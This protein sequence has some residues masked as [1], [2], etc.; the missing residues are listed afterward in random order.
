MI[1]FQPIGIVKSPVTKLSGGNWGEVQSEIHLNASYVGG[2]KG[3]E[4]FSHIVVVFYLDRST[5]VPSEHLLRRPRGR[6]NQPEV[7][8]FA[9]RSKYRPNLI[10]I[11]TVKL[12]SINHNVLTVLALDATDGTPVLDLKPYMP[13]FDKV[14]DATVPAWVAEFEKGYF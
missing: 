3:L 2:L 13:V 12:L 7:G 10:G 1:Q 14:E 11:T 4:E 6:E 5:F 9:Q 8:V